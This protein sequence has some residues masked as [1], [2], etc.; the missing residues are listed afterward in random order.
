[1]DTN[2]NEIVEIYKLDNLNNPIKKTF[3]NNENN[4]VSPKKFVNYKKI[5]FEKK[6]NFLLN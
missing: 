5:Y 3:S 2:S 1:M 6:F 4:N